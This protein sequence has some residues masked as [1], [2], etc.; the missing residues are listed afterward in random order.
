MARGKYH[1][2]LAPDGL[3]RLEIWAQNGLTDEQ[4]SANIG[5]SCS[6]FYEWIKR[7]PEIS[8]TIKKGKIP[9]DEAVENALFK[10]AIGHK[11]TVRKPIKLRDSSGCD[12]VEIVEEE[13]YITPQ[14]TA[15]IF[16]LK[17]RR[18]DK[19]RDK[20]D[21]S[22][23]QGNNELLQ[24]LVDLLKEPKCTEQ[25]PSYT[26]YNEWVAQGKP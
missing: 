6:T 23:R 3:N 13:V 10:S 12:Y 11:E 1:R 16:W 5:I 19:W 9:A 20:P 24:S 18:P 17:N 14:V 21:E 8:E 25:R 22:Q 7:F 15:Q 4:I 2:W 26:T